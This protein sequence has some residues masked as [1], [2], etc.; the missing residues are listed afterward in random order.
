[1]EELVARPG[2]AAPLRAGLRRLGDLERA[3]GQARNATAEPAAGLPAWAVDAAQR[4]REPQQI[5]WA[6]G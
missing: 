6:W 4:R 1:M 2:L 5:R 3:L